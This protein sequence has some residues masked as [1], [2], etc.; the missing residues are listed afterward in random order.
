MNRHILQTA[1]IAAVVVL[2]SAPGQ[3]QNEY[4]LLG[5]KWT[6][7]AAPAEGTPEGEIALIRRHVAR[8]EHGKA[9]RAVKKFLKRYPASDLTEEAMLLAGEAELDREHYF[10]AYE[11]YEKQLDQYPSG[12]YSDRAL[13]REYSIAEA[14]LAGKKRIVLGFIRLP[15]QD[16]GVE[17]L[18]RVA[19]HAPGTD[20]AQRALLTIGDYY[21]GDRQW[22][23]ATEAYDNYVA[24]FPDGNQLRYALLQGARATYRQ[25]RGPRYD[26]TPLLDARQRFD[27]FQS[28]YPQAAQAADVAQ[29]LDTIENQLAQKQLHIARFYARTDKPQG[30]RFYYNRVIELYPD[31]PAAAEA[32]QQLAQMG[33]APQPAMPPGLETPTTTPA[34]DSPEPATQPAPDPQPLRI[35]PD[36]LAPLDQENEN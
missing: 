35:E 29:T 3:G 16:E 17:I 33:P 9:V 21:F 8:N 24:I 7:A 11:W 19:E 2:L 26:E 36:E 32:S 20:L 30:A 13:A 10:Q 1:L 12:Q 34:S 14:F 22:L 4:E 15:A 27:A 18:T 25:Y 28:L 31:T 6:P 23:Q 5:E